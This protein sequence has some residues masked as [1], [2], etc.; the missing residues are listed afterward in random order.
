MGWRALYFGRAHPSEV[1]EAVADASW[2][3]LRRSMK[4]QP[5]EMKY[6]ILP[7]RAGEVAQRT[8]YKCA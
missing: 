3:Q 5:L 2:Q 8:C 4:G 1:R 7:A 6:S